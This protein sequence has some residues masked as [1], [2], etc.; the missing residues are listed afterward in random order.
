[1]KIIG[2]NCVL[3]RTKNEDLMLLHI[4]ML[5]VITT[6]SILWYSFVNKFG[7][8][9]TDQNLVRI[10]V[11]FGDVILLYPAVEHMFHFIFHLL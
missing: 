6:G 7:A 4:N 10:L 1:M 3:C 8:S 9:I 11:L 2:A 5:L